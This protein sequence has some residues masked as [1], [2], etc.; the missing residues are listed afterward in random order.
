MVIMKIKMDEEK[1]LEENI[2]NLKK[3]YE[4][5]DNVFAEFGIK[6]KHLTK[7]VPLTTLAIL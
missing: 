3:V 7:T 6:K 2:Y 1:I 4:C 5:I